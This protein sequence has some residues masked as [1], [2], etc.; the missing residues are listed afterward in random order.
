MMGDW[1]QHGEWLG[2]P[3]LAWVIA[4]AAALGGYLLAH[5]AAAILAA[6]LRKLAERTHRN[7]FAIAARVVEATRGWLLLL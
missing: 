4:G 5:S 7:G 3:A 2:N 6:R 1:L